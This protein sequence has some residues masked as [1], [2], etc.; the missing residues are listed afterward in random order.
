[1]ETTSSARWGSTLALAA[2][3]PIAWGSG[4]YV[5]ETFLPPE[6]PLF[7]ALV[8][9]L[10]FGLVLLAFRPR[11]P[12]GI[13]WWRALVLGTLNIGAFFVLIF[14]AAYRLPGGTAATLTATAPIVVM[15]VAWALIGER[16]RA[17]ALVGAGVGA[18][19]VALLVLRADFAVDPLG[20][21]ASFGAVAMSSVGFVLVKRWKPPVDMLTFTAWQLV[22]GGLVLLPVA[23]LVEGAPPP[24]DPSAIG[25]FLYLGL[26]GTVVAY[27]VWFRGLRRLPAGAVAL[28]GL[29]NPVSGTIIG[30]ALAGESFGGSQALGLL[31]VLA[32][33]LAG[34]P[35]MADRLRRRTGRGSAGDGD[36]DLVGLEVGVAVDDAEPVL[37]DLA[38][39]HG[40]LEGLAADRAGRREVDP[41]AVLEALDREDRA[42]TLGVDAGQLEL[43]HRADLGGRRGEADL[44]LR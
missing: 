40:D 2:L 18:A 12:Q 10:P 19:G 28:V 32:G 34:Q 3:A 35:A 26:A 25:G 5:T 4:Y 14:I 6:R 31:L 37:A 22:A 16:P 36:P 42:L 43:L 13:W 39:L 1:M 11:L 20:V 27:V 21:A 33:I 38:G 17:A 44:G 30:V 9:A 29:L 23:L 41:G 24:L 15:L 7:G 8:R